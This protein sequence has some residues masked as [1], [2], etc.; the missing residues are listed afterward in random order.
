MFLTQR[1]ECGKDGRCSFFQINTY[2]FCS[3]RKGSSTVK[4]AEYQRKT[5]EK[6]RNATII[7]H[8][9]RKSVSAMSNWR[10]LSFS[11]YHKSWHTPFQILCFN[12][13]KIILTMSC[14]EIFEIFFY[15]F[16]KIKSLETF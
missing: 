2:T 14:T 11:V 3:R 4:G 6:I 16:T 13:H 7:E 15:F 8:K 9:S 10:I 5:I 1:I 12:L